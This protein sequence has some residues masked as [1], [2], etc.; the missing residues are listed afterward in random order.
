MDNKQSYKENAFD[1]KELR[2]EWNS[3]MHEAD[4][5]KKRYAEQEKYFKIFG[6]SHSSFKEKVNALLS[7]DTVIEVKPEKEVKVIEMKQKYKKGEKHTQHKLDE[8]PETMELKM[9][10]EEETSYENLLKYMANVLKLAET[11]KNE[12]ER[13]KKVIKTYIEELDRKTNGIG[14]KDLVD[15]LETIESTKHKAERLAH[16]RAGKTIFLKTFTSTAH[17]LD[18]SQIANDSIVA[19]A[20]RDVTLFEMINNMLYQTNSIIQKYFAELIRNHGLENDEEVERLDKALNIMIEG[21]KL[22]QAYQWHVQE[23]NANALQMILIMTKMMNYKSK[24]LTIYALFLENLFD[25]NK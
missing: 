7:A 14:F 21:N 20:Q 6:D 5:L 2:R 19:D 3:I 22:I 10:P 16:Y 13:M 25:E 17:L 1:A 18:L 4:V 15:T 11:G 8:K 9:V 24:L 12:L 23:I